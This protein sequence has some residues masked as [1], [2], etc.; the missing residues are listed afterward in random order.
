MMEKRQPPKMRAKQFRHP[1]F[2]SVGTAF[3][4]FFLQ[5]VEGDIAADR[6][7]EESLLEADKGDELTLVGER[8]GRLVNDGT[9]V[10]YI[11]VSIGA[12]APDTGIVIG[13]L[14]TAGSIGDGHLHMLRGGVEARIDEHE[15]EAVGVVQGLHQAGDR[16]L[17]LPDMVSV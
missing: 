6:R 9:I 10:R 4:R 7:G 12:E 13:P 15:V 11:N 16:V 5:F 17:Y 3:Q 14:G 8:L 1:V 2:L